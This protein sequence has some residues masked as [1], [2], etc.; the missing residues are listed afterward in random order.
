M[1]RS[2]I[3][4]AGPTASGKTA[5]GVQLGQQLDGEIISADSRQ[6][7]RHMDIGTAKPTPAERSATPHHLID[8]VDPDTPY[9][10]DAF[11]H[12]ASALIEDIA[13]RGRQPIV[14][15]GAGF[16]LEAL[17]D[18]LSPVPSTPDEIRKE[19]GERVLSD[20]SGAYRELQR[21]DPKTASSLTGSD[22]QR[23][24]R[25]LEV[26]ASTGH[27]ISHFQAQPRVPATLRKAVHFGLSWDR[28][29]LY[30]R[31]NQRVMTMVDQ[32]LVEEIRSL[33][34][35]GY[36]RKT[37]AL[38]T[39]GYREIGAHLEGEMTLDDA[40]VEMQVGTRHYAKRQLTWFRNR[41]SLRWL[42]A[43]ASENVDIIIA[44]AKRG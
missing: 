10:A 9:S 37:Y 29:R 30:D 25:A 14:V 12:D 26:H 33:F 41:S 19:V 35:L 38:K 22:R 8:I 32:G 23:I 4:I 44:P 28:A 40:I 43:D 36:D 13:G 17:F 11:A 21:V 34:E 15:G 18:G 24:S 2:V 6:I 31:I 5:L 16:Y 42:D 3:V 1:D 20:P 7:Y 27:P 39:F